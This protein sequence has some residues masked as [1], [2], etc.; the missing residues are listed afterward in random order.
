VAGELRSVGLNALFLDP[1]VSGGTETYLRQLVPA[2]AAEYPHVRFSVV[3]TRSGAREL[4]A[5]GWADFVTLH[6]LPTE[7]TQRLRRVLA[8]E[9]LL[10]ALA[11]KQRWQLVHSLANRAPAALAQASVLT[12]HDLISYHAKG[13]SPWIAVPARLTTRLGVRRADA[14][15]ALTSTA[16]EDICHEFALDHSRVSVVPH[17]VGRPA[18]IEPPPGDEIRRRFELDGARVVLCVAAKR[19]HKN[20]ELLVRALPL[21]PA[22]VRVVCAGQDEG[23]ERRLRELSRELGLEDRLR[24]PGYV[25]DEELEGLWRVAGCAAFP[26]LAEG[27]GLP[28]LEAMERGK[29]VACSDIPVLREVAGDAARYFEPHDAKGAAAAIGAAIGD[30]QL[31]RAGRE[32][33]ARFSWPAAARATFAVYERALARRQHPSGASSH[34]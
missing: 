15:V 32:R 1:G 5:V 11:A 22:D 27:F 25:P 7:D 18:E 12:L 6:Q 26:T 31:A 3:T 8:E 29:P 24:L 30:E 9:T 2:L 16:A 34:R 13:M 4:R 23:Y 10:P 20:Q 21:L 19:A 28:V 33:A 14:V 17:G